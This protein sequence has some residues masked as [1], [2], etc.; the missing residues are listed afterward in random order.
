MDNFEFLFE[1]DEE[2]MRRASR[3]LMKIANKHVSPDH[4]FDWNNFIRDVKSYPIDTFVSQPISIGYFDV[5]LMVSKV[6]DFL[7][8]V[9]GEE[10]ENNRL[11]VRIRN[12]VDSLHKDKKETNFLHWYH[13][14]HSNNSSWN[15]SSSYHKDSGIE[16]C[17][18]ST[19]VITK[20]TADKVTKEDWIDGT[21]GNQM[22]NTTI[23]A[24]RVLVKF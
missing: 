5:P 3:D 21:G 9:L 23:I 11:S 22:F 2:R 1:K 19:I 10:V 6:G 18:Y 13:E 12:V 8:K 16:N 7:S 24:M 4:S 15:Y 20:V 17:I 14:E